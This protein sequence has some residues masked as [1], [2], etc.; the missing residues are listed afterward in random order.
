MKTAIGDL[1]IIHSDF[2]LET[3]RECA[4]KLLNS[5]NRPTAI[6][7]VNDPVAIGVIQ[8]AHELGIDIPAELSV[9][10]IDD[11]LAQTSVPPLTSVLRDYQG[12]GRAAMRLL[13][14]QLSGK[15]LLGTVTQ[16]DLGTS[17]T[18]RKTTA[19]A[20]TAAV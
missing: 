4:Y 20:P 11:T 19:N 6:I 8:V 12:M 17:L 1:S 7:A 14:D 13:S 15:T 18:I 16:M 10:G 5:P 2:T 9:I 3:G